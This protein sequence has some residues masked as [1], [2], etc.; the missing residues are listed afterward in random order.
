MIA[1]MTR[2]FIAPLREPSLERGCGD[3]SRPS[4]NKVPLRI[5][6]YD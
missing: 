1:I 3:G 6:R 4:Q 5:T 2:M